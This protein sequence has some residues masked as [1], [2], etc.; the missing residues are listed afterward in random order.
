M[1]DKLHRDA[2]AKVDF[3]ADDWLT[4]TLELTAEQRGVYITLCALYWSKQGR[5]PENDRWLAGM[6]N[7]SMRK[8]RKIKD[9]LVQARKVV[10]I[11]GLLHQ[12]RASITLGNA[13]KV[14]DAARL[15]GALGGQKSAELRANALKPNNPIPSTA[16]NQPLARPQAPAR[17]SSPFSKKE[18]SEVRTSDGLATVDDHAGGEGAGQKVEPFDDPF[19]IPPMLQRPRAGEKAD[20][21]K[22]Q[23]FGPCLAWL[24]SRCPE[25]KPK[26]LRTQIGRWCSRHGDGATL[27]AMIAAQRNN[28]VEP[29]AYIEGALARKLNGSDPDALARAEAH[30]NAGILAGLGLASPD[31][32]ADI[33]PGSVEIDAEAVDAP[34]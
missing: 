16:T 12:Q 9:E 28:P 3:Y 33:E 18:D 5:V 27:E 15:K 4:G 20:N 34:G 22:T 6:C 19:E 23:I 1:A 32:T 31:E 26:T 8:W 11:D 17:A 14:K 13:L 29:R 21:L 25:V 24:Q 2:I 30:D 10:F 7:M